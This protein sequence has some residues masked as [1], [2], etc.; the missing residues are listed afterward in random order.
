MCC[1]VLL[2]S[3]DSVAV[4]R[5]RRRGLYATGTLLTRRTEKVVGVKCGARRAFVLSRSARSRAATRQEWAREWARRGATNE[6]AAAQPLRACEAV[7]TLARCH[8][9]RDVAKLRDCKAPRRNLLPGG[10]GRRAGTC[11][12]ATAAISLSRFSNTVPLLALPGHSPSSHIGFPRFTAFDQQAIYAYIRSP[13][14]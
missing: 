12:S 14:S 10:G 13:S 9:P 8:S 1:S 5:E 4:C 7:S 2:C 11:A 3:G 6:A